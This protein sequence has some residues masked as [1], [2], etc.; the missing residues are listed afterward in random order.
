VGQSADDVVATLLA[1]GRCCGYWQ[2]FYG[3]SVSVKSVASDTVLLPGVSLRVNKGLGVD[4]DE[5]EPSTVAP[6]HTHTQQL[7]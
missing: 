6:P 2:V 5:D 4:M 7:R 3:H 1:S